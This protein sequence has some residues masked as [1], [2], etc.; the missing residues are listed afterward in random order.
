VARGER[1][2]RPRQELALGPDRQDY[3]FDTDAGTASL[4]SF[5]HDARRL[6][7]FTSFF[8]CPIQR[9]V[10]SCSAIA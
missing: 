4:P 2:S 9:Q 10:P 3:R 6:L 7:I 5:S 8:R 1:A